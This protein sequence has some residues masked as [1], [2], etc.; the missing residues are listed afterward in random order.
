MQ[1]AV[2]KYVLMESMSQAGKNHSP[3]PRD[4]KMRCQEA[5]T[6]KVT[7]LV[8]SKRTAGDSCTVAP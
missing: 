4:E 1:V 6:H 2:T 3:H 5:E 8:R 7:Q